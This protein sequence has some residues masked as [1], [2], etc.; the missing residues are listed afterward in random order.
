MA[1]YELV[2]PEFCG[3][4]DETDDLVFWVESPLEQQ[5][6]ASYLKQEL[7]ELVAKITPLPDSSEADFRLPKD[8]SVLRKKIQRNVAR[9]QSH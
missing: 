1:K 8:M 3:G 4:T 6:L 9:H 2:P 7:G 5:L